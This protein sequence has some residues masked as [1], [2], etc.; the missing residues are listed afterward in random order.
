MKVTWD[1]REGALCQTSG[2]PD[3]WYPIG[4]QE[5]AHLKQA[6]EARAWCYGCP[7]RRSCLEAALVEEEGKSKLYR[8]GVRGGLFPRERASLARERAQEA[9]GDGLEA[10]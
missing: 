3:L 9:S 5:A 2:D 6:E 8:Y 7:V 4:F 1:W 10:A